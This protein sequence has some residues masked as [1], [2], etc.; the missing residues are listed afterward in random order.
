MQPEQT[1]TTMKS[2]IK[3][4]HL[5][6]IIGLVVLIGMLVI[7]RVTMK[8]SYPQHPQILTLD[9][10]IMLMEANEYVPIKTLKKGETVS[11]L[12]I[13]KG[14]WTRPASLLVETNDGDRGLLSTVDLGCPQY[15]TEMKDSNLVEVTGFKK[16]DYRS[17]FVI[18]NSVGETKE[19][20]LGD[21]RPVLSEEMRPFVL[22]EKGDYYMTKEKF[23]RLY[24]GQ[25]FEDNEK[26]YRPAMHIHHTNTGCTAYYPN[27]EIVDRK[28]GKIQNPIIEYDANGIAVAY[29]FGKYHWHSNNRYLLMY[30]PWLVDIL[31]N[32]FFA[33]QIEGSLYETS[34][35]WQDEDYSEDNPMSLKAVPFKRWLGLVIYVLFGFIWLF[36]LCTL[37]SLI[38]D[39]SL[40]CRYIYY[41]LPDV[42]VAVIFS[43]VAI[44]SMYI[45]TVLMAVWGCLWIFLPGIWI[46]GI[47][48]WGYSQR[49]LAD[50]PAQ[51]C[52]ECKRMEVNYFRN[53]KFIQEYDEWRQESK[54]VDSRRTH[55][56]TSWTEVT[57]KYS[58]GSTSSRKE[59]V[60]EHYRTD[61]YYDDY[62][63]LY[64]VKE[65]IKYYECAGCGHVEEIP[66]EDLTELQRM[67]TGSHVHTSQS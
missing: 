67:K 64:H 52:P 18:K 26:R 42:V 53:R 46:A 7:N 41:H 39:S 57:T 50:T 23:E 34:W 3:L 17:H 10:S 8:T 47:C 44:A 16:D 65:Y 55:T 13:L 63:V 32:D 24:I 4:P 20:E 38:M 30:L 51:R 45:W 1:F 54:I 19:V 35:S 36:L 37:P 66:E 25:R 60:K 9:R 6:T 5:S 33:R 2:T 61:T 43:G 15:M 48:A 14:D 59:N 27:L 11:Y 40:Y 62:N 22:S 12:G 29:E 21:I 56:G 49:L 58:N 28:E 31:D